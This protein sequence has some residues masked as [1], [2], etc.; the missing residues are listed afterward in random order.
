[1]IWNSK[2][3]KSIQHYD[4]V[5]MMA[6]ISTYLLCSLCACFVCLWLSVS[7]ED[8]QNTNISEI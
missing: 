2:V 3:Q 8:L 1:M 7:S 5:L 4:A 6:V